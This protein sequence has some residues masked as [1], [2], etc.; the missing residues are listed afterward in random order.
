MKLR[1][2]RRAAQDLATISAYIKQ[3]NPPAA[4]RVRADILGSL[5][6]LLLF[7]KIGRE[8]T[9][10]GIRSV[11]TR[12]YGYVVYYS[13]DEANEEVIVIAIQHPARD[14]DDENV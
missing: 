10:E 11:V 1:F 2:T 6:T 12:R 3:R 8:H 13:V 14:R 4:K 5:Q 7:P 9:P